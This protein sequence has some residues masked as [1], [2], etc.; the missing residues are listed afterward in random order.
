MPESPE[1]RFQV[2]KLRPLCIGKQI[3]GI[4]WNKS[5]QRNGVKNIINDNVLPLLVINVWSRGK[6]IVFETKDNQN[7]TLYITSQL[8][9]SGYWTTQPEDHSNLWFLFG[10]PSTQKGLW[11]ITNTIWYDDQRHFGSIGFYRNLNDVWKRHGPCLMTTA[12]I[13]YGFISPFD[14]DGTS[15]IY[16]PDQKTVSLI[17]YQKQI[18]NKR[19]KN[20]RIAEF[21]MDQ[22]RVSGVGNYLRIELLYKA[23]I[24]PFRLLTELSDGEIETLYECTLDIMYRSYISKL[25]KINHYEKDK[26]CGAGFEKLVY[27]KEYDP[28]G[29]KVLKAKDK[30]NRMCYYVAEVQK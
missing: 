19:F 30:N 23:K 12:L 4:K 28:N 21:L 6:V 15:P 10:V 20:K 7:Q 27:K 8:G 11:E 26:E 1:L 14:S 25:T 17:Y 9:M 22:T 2:D 16:H 29:Y 5:F 3:I 13:K 24:S 18:K